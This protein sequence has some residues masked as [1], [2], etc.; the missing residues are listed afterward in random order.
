MSNAFCRNC[1]TELD[2]SAKFCPACGHP[3]KREDGD[4]ATATPVGSVAAKPKP[5]K[6][7]S[8]VGVVL[9][10][11]A[12]MFVIVK[13]LEVAS[14]YLPT[15]E[16]TPTPAPTPVDLEKL[17]PDAAELEKEI[18]ELKKLKFIYAFEPT[19]STVYVNGRIWENSTIDVKTNAAAA[20]A[21][22]CGLKK[23]NGINRVEIYDSHSG[24]RIAKYGSWGL[25][26]EEN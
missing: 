19:N 18:A 10:V 7:T 11:I 25:K 20:L 3:A 16:S 15:S 23:G 24:K 21:R 17:Y 22:Y 4:V 13:I 8:T 1:G 26:I 2:S 14:P 12:A 6:P 9:A 5:R